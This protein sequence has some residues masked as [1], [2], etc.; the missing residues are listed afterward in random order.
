MID[1]LTT[2]KP[3]SVRFDMVN[4]ADAEQFV[5]FKKRLGDKK[6]DFVSWCTATHQMKP[7]ERAA[8][9][10]NVKSILSPLGIAYIEDFA[11]LQ[12]PRSVSQPQSITD[13]HMLQRW[14]T[15]LSFRG[16]IYDHAMETRKR[17]I[18]QVFSFNDSRCAEL[19]MG[20]ANIAMNGER[21]PFYQ[22]VRLAAA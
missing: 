15:P 22:A 21:V 11:S 4:L 13:L 17:G 2:N 14:H 19:T 10:Y 20:L 5:E 1:M 8:M 7:D 12:R 16:F 18:E 9:F 3:A 6:F